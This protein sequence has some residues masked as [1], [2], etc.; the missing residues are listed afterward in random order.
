MEN[1]EILA[2]VGNR[3]ANAYWESSFP[4][5]TRK[6]DIGASMDEVRRKVNDKYIRKLYSPAG[7]PSPIQEFVEAR[8]NGEIT[9]GAF[10]SAKL[11]GM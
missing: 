2:A 10:S 5:H 3:I 6:P 1:I 8:K 7:T 11:S 4:S 9:A